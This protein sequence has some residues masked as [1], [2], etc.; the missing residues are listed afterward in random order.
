[1]CVQT[2]QTRPVIKHNIIIVVIIIIIIAAGIILCARTRV[3]TT[4]RDSAAKTQSHVS[5][6][7]TNTHV[8]NIRLYYYYY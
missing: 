4:F 6:A 8:H 5:S 2:L 3:S 1:M 7:G